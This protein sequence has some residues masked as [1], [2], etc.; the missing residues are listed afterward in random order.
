MENTTHTT[1][2]RLRTARARVRAATLAKERLDAE[3]AALAQ[4][5]RDGKAG[6][7]ELQRLQQLA[8]EAT[9][10]SSEIIDAGA[11]ETMLESLSTAERRRSDSIALDLTLEIGKQRADEFVEHAT[12]ASVAL[13]KLFACIEEANALGASVSNSSTLGIALDPQR[14]AAIASLNT[15][16]DVNAAAEAKGLVAVVGFGWRH[17]VALVP[18]TSKFS[19]GA[20]I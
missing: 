18:R 13:G 19:Q 1:E 5:V 3:I 12:A 4:M 7:P 11:S 17:S 9:K 10:L 15:I 14:R 20:V 6:L 2:A 8:D 16:P